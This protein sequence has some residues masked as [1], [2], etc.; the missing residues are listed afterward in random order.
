MLWFI[1]FLI[2]AA[3]AVAEMIAMGGTI[4]GFK[5]RMHALDPDDREIYISYEDTDFTGSAGFH[6]NHLPQN[7]I[8]IPQA[9]WLVGGCMAEIEYNVV[10][11][12]RAWLRVAKTGKLSCADAYQDMDY[13]STMGYEIDDVQVLHRQVNGGFTMI[14]WSR[15]GYD[16][17]FYAPEPQMNAMNGSV[18]TLIRELGV[19]DAA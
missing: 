16:F 18:D 10:P 9:Y 17:M 6:I 4:L 12:Q 13:D 7:E 14:T 3:V 1:L 8:L 19:S 11:S 2:A 5:R 15:D